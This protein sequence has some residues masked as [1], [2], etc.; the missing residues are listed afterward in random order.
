MVDS[1]YIQ[2]NQGSIHSNKRE[3]IS[4]YNYNGQDLSL[5]MNGN[6]YLTFNNDEKVVD[7]NMFL[8]LMQSLGMEIVENASFEEL[9]KNQG[10]GSNGK[11]FDLQDY[12]KEMSFMYRKF[13][14]KKKDTVQ[15]SGTFKTPTIRNKI[16]SSI[17]LKDSLISLLKVDSFYNLIDH[18]NYYKMTYNPHFFKN[19]LGDFYQLTMHNIVFIDNLDYYGGQLFCQKKEITD[20]KKK[21]TIVVAKN[22]KV[23]DPETSY[24]NYFLV[25]YKGKILQKTTKTVPEWT[26]DILESTSDTNSE[27]PN[28]SFKEPQPEPQP[29]SQLESVPEPQPESQPESQLESVP[30]SVPNIDFTSKKVAELKD[31]LRA[32]GLKVSGKRDELIKRLEQE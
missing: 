25:M 19:D 28:E 1:E 23:I 13:V 7:K 8:E 24:T 30:K 22:I 12:E 3:I 11:V 18:V 9:Y 29:E 5:Y 6:N 14:F 15:L 10:N 32:R 21:Y 17:K 31:L 4:Y 2:K 26:L 20:N 16:Q 27:T